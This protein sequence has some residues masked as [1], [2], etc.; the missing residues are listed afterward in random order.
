MS[1]HR[2][3][4]LYKAEDMFQHNLHIYVNRVHE[5]FA[6]MEHSHDFIEICYV[7]DGAGTHYIQNRTLSVTQGD[8]FFLPVGTHHV[9]RPIYQQTSNIHWLCITVYSSPHS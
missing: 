9:F 6:T 5:S 8:I 1:I 2:T 3:V 4:E 7:G